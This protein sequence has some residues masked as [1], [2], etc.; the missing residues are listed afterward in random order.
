VADEP[1]VGCGSL[2][3]GITDWR[4]SLNAKGFYAIG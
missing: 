1:F 2:G 4:L 3:S